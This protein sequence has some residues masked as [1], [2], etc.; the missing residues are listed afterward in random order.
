MSQ[1]P[2]GSWNKAV[3]GVVKTTV[4]AARAKGS[5]SAERFMRKLSRS[6]DR[7]AADSVRERSST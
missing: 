3:P 4:T 2:N 5:A 7:T 1:G 6:S